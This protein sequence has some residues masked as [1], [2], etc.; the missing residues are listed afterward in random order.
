MQNPSKVYKNCQHIC[1][2]GIIALVAATAA[3]L[4]HGLFWQFAI[5]AIGSL[6]GFLMGYSALYLSVADGDTKVEGRNNAN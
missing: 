5:L 1:L 2:W 4:S 6:T 3:L